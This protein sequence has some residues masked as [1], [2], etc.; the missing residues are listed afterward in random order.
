MEQNLRNAIEA[1]SEKRVNVKVAE[2]QRSYDALNSKYIALIDEAKIL[3][4]DFKGIA[5][6]N[7]LN[8][9]KFE[10]FVA[11]SLLANN[12]FEILQWTSDKGFQSDIS[13]AAHGNP[14]FEV[15]RADGKLFAIECKYRSVSY[16]QSESD[17]DISWA[18]DKQ[19]KR[20]R[21][22]GRN[23]KMPVYI[24]LGFKGDA[25]NPECNYVINLE[26]LFYLSIPTKVEHV[27]KDE[28]QMI[29]GQ[30]QIYNYLVKDQNFSSLIK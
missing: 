2:M 23:Q 5:Y 16:F 10:I 13:V 8:G 28:L 6:K 20:Y 19:A 24:A 25:E 12:Q 15:K 21:N 9:R 22:F 4:I 17:E 14:D 29:V 27:K 7:I 18:T 26:H 11:K 1:E 30:P 3:D